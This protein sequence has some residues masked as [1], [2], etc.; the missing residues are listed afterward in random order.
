M[1]PAYKPQSRSKS[2]PPARHFEL[3]ILESLFVACLLTVLTLVL[4]Q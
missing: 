1:Q 3:R 2:K 4:F